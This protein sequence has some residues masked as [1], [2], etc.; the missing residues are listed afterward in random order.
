MFISGSGLSS[1][2]QSQPA[3][4]AARFLP[5]S[6][7]GEPGAR[8]Y[9]T[10]DLARFSGGSSGLQFLGRVDAQVK[11]RGVRIE[12]GDIE[13]V[14]VEREDIR[15]AAVVVPA[16]DEHHLAAYLVPANPDEPPS[17]LELRTHLAQRLPDVMV[18]SF[19]LFTEALPLNPNG[20]VDRLALGHRPLPDQNHDFC[21]S[22]LYCASGSV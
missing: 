3:L 12:P 9:R 7:G 13:A 4:T 19:Y 15:A 17:A 6:M 14:L 16:R 10:G 11:L 21:G 2:Y 5:D 1:G 22:S 8:I 20:K 18:P